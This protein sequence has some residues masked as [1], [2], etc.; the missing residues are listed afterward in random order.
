MKIAYYISNHGF[1]HATRSAALIQELNKINIFTFIC[2]N[3]PK[4]LFD[5]IS[6]KDSYYRK[7]KLDFGVFQKDLFSPD[8]EKTKNS[9]FDLWQRK[10]EIIQQEVDFFQSH[11]IDLIIA[12]IPPFAFDIGARL[13]VPVIAVSN[14]DWY[15]VYHNLFK[16]YMT[17]VAEK[18]K[19]NTIIDEI[20][21]MQHQA[22]YAIK[23]P[24][25]SNQS[26]EEYPEV[27]EMGVLA[28]KSVNERNE[29]CKKYNLDEDKKI[30]L[31]GF[32][33]EGEN[34]ISEK[35]MKHFDEF[36]V[37]SRYEIENCIKINPKTDYQSLLAS[38]DIVVT[39]VGYSTLA[40]SVQ[41]GKYI[42]ATARD[43]Y[44]EDIV[45]ID[46]LLK[47]PYQ[48]FIPAQEFNN[49]NW[50]E[51]LKYAKSQK[52]QKLE[53]YANQNREIAK[54]IISKFYA[55]IQNKIAIIVVGSNNVQLLWAETNSETIIHEATLMT[56]LGKNMKDNLL[57]EEAINRTK[58]VLKD[59][60]ELSLPFSDKISV[61]GTSCSREAK[62][63]DTLSDWM[64]E[65][66]TIKY[67]II[68]GETESYLN[69]FANNEAENCNNFVSF[70]L[71]GGS[72]EF[73]YIKNNKI[74]KIS[75]VPI[76]ILRLIETCNLQDIP[77]KVDE[78]LNEVFDTFNFEEDKES[79]FKL[80]GIGGTVTSIA[81]ILLNQDYYDSEKI[82]GYQIKMSELQKLIN[83]VQK[84]SQNEIEKLLF[85]EPLRREIFLLGMQ[86]I[87]QIGKKY[88]MKKI[89]VSNRSIQHGLLKKMSLRS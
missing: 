30:I 70:D 53:K 18:E 75:S 62:N 16:K 29:L 34:P 4:Y 55:D 11:K 23:L 77:Q 8:L 6:K 17:T 59:Y 22:G 78:L 31:L 3:R 54:L 89:E 1:G 73:A 52:T 81:A 72:T 10:D 44:P 12:D 79:D 86:I 36:N 82:S 2:T 13:N 68:S 66:Y 45:L 48:Q 15:Y 43:N 46:E 49:A 71:G 65:K 57:D 39:K 19:L 83:N 21:V 69:A 40:E 32:G 26:M 33:G 60:I 38:A 80:I 7:T 20:K 63:I 42:I 88:N 51:I 50:K 14:F 61:V 25:S 27:I 84:M 64:L 56:S 67:E 41:N 5:K 37:F 9:L 24:F 87:Y 28:Q 74:E 58:K 47:Y 76:G 85:F 35:D